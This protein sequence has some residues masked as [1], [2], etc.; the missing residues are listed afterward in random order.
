MDSSFLPLL[1]IPLV[2][3][4]NTVIVY[5]DCAQTAIPLVHLARIKIPTV[6]NLAVMDIFYNANSL[7][8]IIV[9]LKHV[10]KVLILR[11]IQEPVRIV[12]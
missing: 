6:A 1:V 7:A 11:Q 9:V 10:L 4:V 8:I 12:W 3:Q 5:Q 2:L